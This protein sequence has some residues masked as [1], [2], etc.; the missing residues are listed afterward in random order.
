MNIHRRLKSLLAY[1]LVVAIAVGGAAL[2]QNESRLDAAP[3]SKETVRFDVWTPSDSD[4]VID[5]VF[6]DDGNG[7]FVSD[8]S[9]M[10][11]GAPGK[12]VS[13]STGLHR[14]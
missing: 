5:G 1:G 13:W 10:A 7:S 2:C 11:A 6:V 9:G 12:V 4:I 3:P 8:E 14:R